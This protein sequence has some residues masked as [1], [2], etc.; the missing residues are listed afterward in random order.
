M[1]LIWLA[2]ESTPCGDF[3]GDFITETEVDLFLTR[4][5]WL[6]RTTTLLDK[7]WG[8]T[9]DDVDYFATLIKPSR[10]IEFV[11][12]DYLPKG[13]VLVESADRVGDFYRDHFQT[14]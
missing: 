3:Y 6:P 9:I 8:I 7:I 2:K 13:K 11:D 4:R 1:Y 12:K 10:R 14:V 5:G